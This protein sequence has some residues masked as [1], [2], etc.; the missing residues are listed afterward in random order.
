M[1]SKQSLSKHL[2]RPADG[3]T[4][5]VWL[6]AAFLFLPIGSK[7]CQKVCQAAKRQNGKAELL[8]TLFFSRPHRLMK[9]V[10][11][12]KRSS[13]SVLGA[14]SNEDL[15][16]FGLVVSQS[17]PTRGILDSRDLI[18]L[19]FVM[20]FRMGIP[21]MHISGLCVPQTPGVTGDQH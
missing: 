21:V 6:P 20:Q 11:V 10:P 3:K 13:G 14:P 15:D 18:V 5:N 17:S 19:N 12:L 4:M 9:A 7:T 1:T 8:E 2:R 16:R